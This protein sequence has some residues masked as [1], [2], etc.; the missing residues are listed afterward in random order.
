MSMTHHISNQ[1]TNHLVS[2]SA[3]LKRTGCHCTR[4]F[5]H[6]SPSSLPTHATSS[7][8]PMTKCPHRRPGSASSHRRFIETLASPPLSVCTALLTHIFLIGRYLTPPHLHPSC[9]DPNQSPATAI[10]HSLSIT[11]AVPSKKKNMPPR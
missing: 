3:A 7:S 10:D 4:S 5:A 9:K 2:Q 11:T 6:Q 1:C 8:S